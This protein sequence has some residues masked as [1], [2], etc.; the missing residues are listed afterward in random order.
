V[1]NTITKYV[2]ECSGFNTHVYSTVD[3]SKKC[4]QWS[5]HLCFIT[6][7]FACLA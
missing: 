1:N 6:N 5:L 7:M 2:I 3:T 4:L